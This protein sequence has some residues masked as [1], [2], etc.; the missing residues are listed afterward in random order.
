MLITLGESDRAIS[1]NISDFWSDTRGIAIRGWV[2]TKSQR[3]EDLE[4]FCDGT[5]VPL[6]SWHR[7]DDIVEKQPPGFLGMAWGFWCYLPASSTPSVTIRRRGSNARDGTT[8]QLKRHPPKIPDAEKREGGSLFE[9]FRT[10]ANRVR[11]AILEI[12]SRQVVKGGE[13]K[14][15]LFPDCRF[16]GFDYYPDANT[17]VIGDAHELSKFFAAEF[18]AVFSLAVFEHFAM[19]WVVAAEINKILKVGGLTFHSTHFAFPLHEQPWDFWRYTDQSLRILFSPPL[20]FEVIGIEFDTPAR[21]HPDTPRA[22][23][24]HLPMEP[25]WV[26]ISVFARKTAN[27]DPAKFI[28]SASVPDCLGENSRYPPPT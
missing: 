28:W 15:S 19:P 14:R 3:P 27:I 11:G 13:C 1:V 26:G 16:V 18:D 2:S 8:V 9:E 5:S 4:F 21:M 17:D 12:G 25:V 23:L 7:R 10:E 6:T 24:M 22:E 20:G